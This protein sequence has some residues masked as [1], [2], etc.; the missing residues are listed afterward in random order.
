MN[1]RYGVWAAA[2]CAVLAVGASGC[3][4]D[5]DD[6]GG[7][8]GGGTDKPAI[9]TSG[10]E[11][12]SAQQISEKAKA[13]LLKAT[14]MRMKIDGTDGGERIRMNLALDT[15]GNCR[16][17][18]SP[19]GTGVIEIVKVGDRVWMKPDEAAWKLQ[20]GPQQG[21][22]T[23]KLF[24]GKWLSGTTS[25]EGLKEMAESCD[26]KSLQSEAASESFDDDF[27]KGT[28]ETLNGQQV[29]P[30]KGRNDKGNPETLYVAITGK[31]Y[32]V[33]FVETGKDGGTVELSDYDKPIPTDTPTEAES[34]NFA[35]FEDEL[36]GGA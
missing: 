34:I 4:K 32:P 30:L 10:V 12:L 24:S 17:S 22:E 13:E 28:P 5:S 19:D 25:D 33:K 23:A 8:T 29:I 11:K 31:P 27:T 18:I 20:L 16:G 9:T 36:G 6:K 1:K 15:T 3:G 21:A 35:E 14:S 2:A 26:L 7:R